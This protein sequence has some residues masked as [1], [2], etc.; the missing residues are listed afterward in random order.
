LQVGILLRNT[1]LEIYGEIAVKITFIDDND[2]NETV[3][4]DG[5]IGFRILL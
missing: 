2:N 3:D 1:P 4:L 5:G